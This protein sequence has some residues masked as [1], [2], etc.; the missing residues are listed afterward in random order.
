MTERKIGL[1][2]VRAL[3]PGQT[4]W[5]A[6]V[7]GFGARRQQ[8]PAVSYVLIYRT[9]EGR[10][11][12]HTIGRHGAPWTPETA[13]EESKR[14]LGKVVDGIDP[15]AVKQAKRKAATV[16]E[17]CDLYLADAEAGRLL[18]RRKLP[19]KA[20]TL[21]IDRG[22]IARHIKPLLGQMKVA[23]VTRED[24][25]GFMHDIALGKTAGNTKTARK[26]GLARVRGGK[27]AASR[28]VG[29]LGGIFTY[30]VGH[31]MRADNPVRGVIR[32]ADGKRERRLS[33]DE[34]KMLGEALRLA[35]AKRIWPAAVA[36]A[37]FLALTGWRSGEALEL[38]WADIDLV[39]RTATLPN[40]KTG[41]SVRALSRASCDMLR[42]RTRS[43]DLVFPAT[44]GDTDVI[45]SGFKKM[46]KKIAELGK[47]SA[48]VTPHTLRH[49]FTSLA[50]DLGYS[51]LTI[52][53]LVGHKGRTITSRY[54]HSADAVLLSAADT[55]ANKTTAL[56]SGNKDAIEI[57]PFRRESA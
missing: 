53:A 52:G 21:T 19:K 47:L 38:R 7:A 2:E 51:E 9:Q 11:R 24:V 45:M 12:W 41:R 40:T 20:S 31:R 1:R 54:V 23:A 13:R 49:S 29:L 39:R 17:L 46:W 35:E 4:I 5:D 43:S 30:A 14:L 26:R 33:D 22:R 3:K 37:R 36:A 56:M 15:S 42:N 44:R 10:Q 6:A 18:T 57:I 55:V 8:S 16:A 48:D 27:G 28:A 50:A 32:F 25:D 34:Y